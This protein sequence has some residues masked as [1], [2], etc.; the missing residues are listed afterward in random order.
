[1]KL[2]NDDQNEIIHFNKQERTNV[3]SVNNRHKEI[4]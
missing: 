2:G 1:M 3:K 4:Y